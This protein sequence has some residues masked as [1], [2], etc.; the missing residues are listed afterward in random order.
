MVFVVGHQVTGSPVDSGRGME[1][2]SFHFFILF[3]HF[4]FRARPL[5]FLY[6]IIT[7][8]NNCS[9]LK[10]ITIIII[11][12]RHVFKRGCRFSLPRV[13]NVTNQLS[14]FISFQVSTARYPVDLACLVV[15]PVS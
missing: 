14:L 8:R 13:S 3:F 10:I 11:I 9:I 15:P 4:L 6:K 7:R 1:L 12:N 5:D 2:W